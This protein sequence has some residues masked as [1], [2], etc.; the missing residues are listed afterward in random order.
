MPTTAY[1][2]IIVS[3]TMASAML[4]A[5]SALSTFD[6]NSRTLSESDSL[7]ND[8]LVIMKRAAWKLKDAAVQWA[9]MQ[10]ARR[11]EVAV[12]KMILAAFMAPDVGG[13]WWWRWWW[14]WWWW[15]WWRWWW[16]WWWWWW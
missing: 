2:V 4:C 11:R 15:W 8:E 12:V 1:A 5:A 14:W 7:G 6:T 9:E 3:M 10:A 16:W 13:G